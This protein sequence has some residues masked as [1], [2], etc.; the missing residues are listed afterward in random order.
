MKKLLA[1]LFTLGLAFSLSAPVFATATPA[2]A[3]TTSSK[4]HKKRHK[5]AKKS[6]KSS[7]GT[8]M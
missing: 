1:L 3:Q 5:K 8:G 7:A 2:G 6:K 4:K